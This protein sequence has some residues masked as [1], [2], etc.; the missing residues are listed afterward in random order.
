MKNKNTVKGLSLIEL[1]V[2][3]SI[4]LTVMS[5]IVVASRELKYHANLTFCTNNMRQ[6]SMAL[7]TYYNDHKDYPTGLPYDTLQ[8]QLSNY[9]SNRKT[10][11]CPQDYNESTDSYSQFYVYPGQDFGTNKYILGCPRH[12]R[13]KLSA[14][15]FS[16]QVATKNQVANVNGNNGKI[17]PGTSY[18]GTMHLADGT[19]VASSD[20][21]MQLIQSFSQNNG[22]LYTIIR[23]PD[24]DTGSISVEATKGTNLEIV[25][26]SLVAAVRG[27][28]FTIE[29][30]YD[31]SLSAS[32]IS[33]SEGIVEVMPIRGL[34]K[35]NNKIVA[36]GIKAMK[37]V[38]GDSAEIMNEQPKIKQKV[39]DNRVEK[40]FKKIQKGKKEGDDVEKDVALYE[41]LSK[42]STNNLGSFVPEPEP[43]VYP[44]SYSTSQQ[45]QQAASQANKDANEAYDEVRSAKEVTKNAANVAN[46]EANKANAATQ[47]AQNEAAKVIQELSREHIEQAMETARETI[48]QASKSAEHAQEAQLFLD[49]ALQAQNQA[50]EG[51][52]N[53]EFFA[54]LA[55]TAA[56]Q[57]EEIASGD[58][59]QTTAAQMANTEA[60]R[61]LVEAQRALAEYNRTA[62]E[63]EKAAIAAE[64]AQE[65][66]NLAEM[67]A[68]NAREA[69]AGYG[70]E[71]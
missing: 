7:A 55:A 56:T 38:E 53:A 45:A 3:M 62:T 67:F 12:K 35:E 15:I 50:L 44:S 31:N 70:F 42:F 66:A 24:G 8:N 23:V 16:L 32:N 10:F 20:I 60:Q 17:L 39:I 29:V 68:N 43:Y 47:R 54:S 5:I 52:E 69:V 18:S 37:L 13:G 28:K 36:A 61:A 41:W 57:A 59:S 1:L 22:M 49:K 64:V 9:L 26:P 2:V 11:I 71:E 34:R 63:V 6:I 25:T 27:T 30:G 33:V 19:T 51:K 48:L 4:L 14:N 46:M 21:E 58:P 40:L 65:K